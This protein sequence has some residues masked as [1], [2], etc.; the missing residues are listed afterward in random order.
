MTVAEKNGPRAPGAGQD[1]LFPNVGQGFSN[2]YVS[3]RLT[4]SP[5][6]GAA[7]SAALPGAQPAGGKPLPEKLCPLAQDS[8]GM[9]LFI[10][11]YCGIH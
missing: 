1:R 9:K 11:G 5:L 6:A 10:A 7:F 2:Q 4:R 8:R 3:T